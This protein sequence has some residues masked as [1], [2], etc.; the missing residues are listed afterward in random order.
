MP[1]YGSY[2][3]N[4]RP[5]SA[6]AA[7]DGGYNNGT[8]SLRGT[9]ASLA[10]SSGSASFSDVLAADDA[11]QL[12]NEPYFHLSS[13]QQD[14][15]LDDARSTA[16]ALIVDTLSGFDKWRFLTVTG[17]VQLFELKPDAADRVS[18][19]WS[20]DASLAS[21]S[22][23]VASSSA[24]SASSASAASSGAPQSHTLLAVTRVRAK[25]DD[26]MRIAATDKR[27]KF[28]NLLA[29]LHKDDVQ[30]AD[31]FTA[32]GSLGTSG[33][34]GGNHSGASS[35]NNSSTDLLSSSFT[36]N[37]SFGSA[38]GAKNAA[39]AA[40]GVDAEQYAIKYFSLKEPKAAAARATV[41]NKLLLG[42]SKAASRRAKSA[43]GSDGLTLCVGEYATIRQ[44]KVRANA[45]AQRASG[46]EDHRIGIIASH[47]LEDPQI[48]RYC[49]PI[50]TT[51]G[52]GF[53][54]TSRSFAQFSGTVVYPVESSVAGES[55]LEV[56]VKLSCFDAAGVS[57]LKKQAM[58]QYLVALRRLEAA[59]LVL[60]LHDS[61]FL[62]SSNW[63]KSEQRK[64]CYVC[65]QSF[66][67]FRRKHHCRLCGE[68]VCSKCS[69]M[70]TIKLAKSGASAFRVCS[71]CLNGSAG[72][73]ASAGAQRPQSIKCDNSDPEDGD[74][75][76]V[77]VDCQLEPI[78][79]SEAPPPKPQSPQPQ[80]RLSTPLQ[81][82]EQEQWQ[83]NE[84]EP[85]HQPLLHKQQL[86]Q[87]DSRLQRHECESRSAAQVQDKQR[88]ESTTSSAE[89]EF[90]DSRGFLA[91]N[92][93]ATTAAST[94]PS[95]AGSLVSSSPPSPGV[96]RESEPEQ[97]FED[98]DRGSEQSLR[99]FHDSEFELNPSDLQL[100]T[101]RIKKDTTVFAIEECLEEDEES[102]RGVAARTSTNQAAKLSLPPQQHT[103]E[104]FD[105]SRASEQFDD[106][107]TLEQFDDS[108]A[109]EQFDDS[110]TSE[111]FDD[112]RTSE[113]FDDNRA[114]EQSLR[115]FHDSEFELDLSDLN[116]GPTVFAIN[117]DD[118]EEDERSTRGGASKSN[119]TQFVGRPS[120]QHKEEQ[121]DDS[122]ASEQ[123][124]DSRTSEQFDDSR[125]SEQFDDNR[126]SE[127]SLRDFHD[128]EF[129][130]D[131]SDLNKGPTVFAINE[132]DDE[133]DERSTRG[134]PNEGA[135]SFASYDP[136]DDDDDDDDRGF[137]FHDS[138]VG[139]SF[140]FE[141]VEEFNDA[142]YEAMEEIQEITTTS[143]AMVQRNRL[144]DELRSTRLR[145]Y[146]IMD[147]PREA[148]FDMIAAQAAQF[149]SC[150]L[151]SV[152]F[153]DDRREFV[154]AVS[155]SLMI[156][157]RSGGMTHEIH[158]Q[159]S[160]AAHIVQ[161]CAAEELSVVLVLD[162]LHDE[163]LSANL[164][165]YDAPFLRFI[166]G[167]PVTTRDGVV[168]GA[169]V[170]AD[171]R[172][173]SEVTPTERKV[174]R[175]F[176]AQLNE[177]MDERWQAE[178]F[179]RRGVAAPEQIHNTLQSL[180][181]Q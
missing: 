46:L 49:K 75:D 180:L 37:S 36:S 86:E 139:I 136:A 79:R 11:P 89:S 101:H 171:D 88:A 114:S 58:L 65:Q 17:N 14:A 135:S 99:D 175:D 119:T 118:D 96:Q 28:Q 131:L 57:S 102:S 90:N 7:K 109:S 153:V 98:S 172:P 128:S 93:T 10:S 132:D 148:S 24:S 154:K 33:G 134:A 95:T 105:A 181:S 80:Q 146:A 66:P 22:A 92:V 145:D 40:C 126:A 67:S 38:H 170:V 84:G 30:H 85:P 21:S 173:R 68:V 97:Q 144:L 152:S 160:V 140:S 70:H 48:T 94:P 3:L 5:K 23:S 137:E 56:V 35:H 77:E 29:Y 157:S 64:A 117:E 108:R 124:D 72:A 156:P 73:G 47:S 161:R 55:V 52:A 116:K 162:A 45:L 82:R 129:E 12:S 25:L 78:V 74:E 176:A 177:L 39:A 158:K 167:I 163:A 174:L 27:D 127:Q 18:A 123:F 133:E 62:S 115:D 122:R 19:M 50:A 42:K 168:L 106:S 142:K 20:D 83:P 9:T 32:F 4:L 166:V 111:Q 2:A 81:S 113:Q 43:S 179:K 54:V 60:R 169:L 120:P 103:L 41:A 130:L 159:H 151:A 112:N 125:T 104:Q 34:G 141:E 87:H 91:S 1:N 150:S 164:F 15:L 13:E 165:V 44:G 8:S 63:A 31:V 61:P 59:L 51:A 69:S 6:N 149:M 110:R 71:A 147:S 178:M 26:F 16:T 155:G 107:R 53:T 76:A 138:E 100:D 143:A 121:F